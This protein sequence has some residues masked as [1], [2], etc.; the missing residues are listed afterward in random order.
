MAAELPYLASYKNVAEL[1]QRI[2][3]AKKPENF[4]TR[5]LSETIGLKNSTDRQLIA[6]L[7]TLGFLDSAG[8]PT[9]NYDQLKNSNRAPKA[10]ADAVR[11]AYEPLYAANEN[12]HNLSSSELKGLIS[13]VAGSDTGMTMKIQ[14]TYTSLV[15]ISDFNEE[16][17]VK[18]E[19]NLTI[20]KEADGSSA[21]VERTLGVRL[22]PE[23]HYNIQI[24]LPA[25]AT[26]ET[27]LNIFN[28][29]RRSFES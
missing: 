24:H 7:K 4:T 25:N 2:S 28:A 1:F 20:T 10:I 12:A 16:E 21:N 14:G 27:Y 8:R 29:L 26:E 19:P 17:S 3:S 15:K 22:K 23:F 6:F 5:Y 18:N 13:Q 11:R 9:P